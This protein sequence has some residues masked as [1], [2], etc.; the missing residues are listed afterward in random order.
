MAIAIL[1]IDLFA[2]LAATHTHTHE[3]VQFNRLRFAFYSI[4]DIVSCFV[5]APLHL[6]FHFLP[7]IPWMAVARLDS[8]FIKFLLTQ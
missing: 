5:G 6:L 8:I 3:F 4:P 7:S 2:E 1:G